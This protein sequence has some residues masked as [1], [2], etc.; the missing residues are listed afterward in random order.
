MG[1]I[2]GKQVYL[3]TKKRLDEDFGRERKGERGI[4]ERESLGY[5]GG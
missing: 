2:K 1:K 5:L 3:G 4:R